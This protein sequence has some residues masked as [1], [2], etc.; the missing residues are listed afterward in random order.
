MLFVILLANLLVAALKMI[1]GT[2]IHSASMTADGYH[3]L[4]DGMSNIIGLIG[5]RLA[6]KPKDADHPYGHNKFETLAGLFISAM[7]FFIGGK[8]IFDAISRFRE[9]VALDITLSS[10][11]ALLLTLAVNIFV[12]ITEYR[13]GKE[14]KSQILISDSMHTRG[15]IYISIGV[16]VALAG[17]KLGLPP[18]IDPIV[19]LI[20]SVFILHAAIEIFKENSNV[21]VDHSVAD[22]EEIRKLVMSFESV[23]DAHNIRSRGSHYAFFIDLHILIDPHTTTEKAH[24]LVHDIEEAVRGKINPNAEVLIHV[25]PYH[26][27]HTDEE[28][29]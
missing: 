24:E 5:I 13:K 6:M 22:T 1:I 25:E 18:I 8:V 11:M 15:D 17:I 20:V 19:S 12:S 29:T 4:S 2:Y 10:L 28:N 14:L 23:K 3:S 9:P 26:E 27:N 21:L 7:L 16:L